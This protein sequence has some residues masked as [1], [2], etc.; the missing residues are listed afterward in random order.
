MMNNNVQVLTFV[1]CY[2]ITC[3]LENNH[4]LRGFQ[5]DIPQK[6]ISNKRDT[7]VFCEISPETR[8]V[9][10]LIHLSYI[11]ILN[12]WLLDH[13]DIGSISISPLKL[14]HFFCNNRGMVYWYGIYGIF[15]QK[16][17]R[18]YVKMLFQCR[19]KIKL[20]YLIL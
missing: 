12:L 8:H 3:I 5:T 18:S 1:G 4:I 2:M 7:E 6:G 16:L 11:F 14:W 17:F 15:G 10:C 20:S 19:I 9:S 13:Y